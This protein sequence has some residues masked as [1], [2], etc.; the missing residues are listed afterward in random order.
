MKDIIISMNIARIS[1]A[2]HHQHI[3]ISITDEIANI[4]F[5]TVSMSFENFMKCLTGLSDIKG[6]GK[7]S[8]LDKV[9]KIHECELFEFPLAV[10]AGGSSSSRLDIAIETAER[11]CPNGW[12]PD[13]YFGSQNSFFEKDGVSY[14][15]C[16][17]RRWRT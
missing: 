9:G 7:V 13:L 12:Q 2:N 5:V 4:N 11:L 1:D 6:A 16:T 10:F 8:G 3:E 17:I 15:R 14:A